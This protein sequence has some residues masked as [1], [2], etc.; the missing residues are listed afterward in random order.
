[1]ETQNG[2]RLSRKSVVVVVVVASLD[3]PRGKDPEKRYRRKRRG[4]SRKWGG[5]EEGRRL[6]RGTGRRDD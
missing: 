6:G 5:S 3:L 2:H 1:M 4:N